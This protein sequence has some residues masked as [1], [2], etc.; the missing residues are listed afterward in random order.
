MSRRGVTVR[1]VPT[2]DA[3]EVRRSRRR[4]RTVTAWREGGVTVV[5]IPARFTR[6]Q[7][8]EWV[9]RMLGRL[10]VQDERRRPSDA[11]LL[12]RATELSREYLD[13]RAVPAS[14]AWSSRQ[15]KRWGSCTTVDR[16]IR[17]SDRLQGMPRWVLDY[18]LMH[19]LAHLLRPGH[20]GSFWALVDRY[21]H[22]ARAR[23]FL[24]GYA[25]ARGR[26]EAGPDDDDAWDVDEDAMPAPGEDGDPRRAVTEVGAAPD[27]APDGV[28]FDI[29]TT[30]R[31]S[32]GGRRA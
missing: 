9:D 28:L 31:P 1:S 27:E 16:T 25:Y 30:R 6:A 17:I 23:G 4:T 15:G 14:V 7:E 8:R 19:E 13:G 10:A 20:D 26:G 11:G 21:P 22:T 5:S 2:P 29:G 12:R 24:D 3:V 18:V 32:L